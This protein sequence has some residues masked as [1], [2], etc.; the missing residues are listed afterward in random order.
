M[1]LGNTVTYKSDDF[2]PGKE[3]VG[4]IAMLLSGLTHL[5]LPSYPAKIQS[6]SLYTVAPWADLA[7][8][9]TKETKTLVR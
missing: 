4:W 6:L 1:K 8:N 7:T 5:A 2:T 9:L 3:N